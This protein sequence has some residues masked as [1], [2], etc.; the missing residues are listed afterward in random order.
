[1]CVLNILIQIKK[2]KRENERLSNAQEGLASQGKGDFFFKKTNQPKRREREKKT[3]YLNRA[4][5]PSKL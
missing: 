2:T 5:K 3:I 1:M 4:I